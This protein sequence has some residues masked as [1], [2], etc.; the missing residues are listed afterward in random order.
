MLSEVL[1][2]DRLFSPSTSHYVLK[3][4]GYSFLTENELG[5]GDNI[6]NADLSLC[7]L[8]LSS[9]ASMSVPYLISLGIL[10]NRFRAA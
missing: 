8:K 1:F 3:T 10:Y 6:S 2:E 5:E 9:P 7:I 4:T